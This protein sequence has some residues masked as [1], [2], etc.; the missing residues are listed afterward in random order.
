[1]DK[2]IYKVE[3]IDQ[4]VRVEFQKGA[5][6]SPDV[7]IE[8]MNYE[9]ELFDIKGRYDFWDF[10]GC[11]PSPNFGYDAMSRVV[12]HITLNYN[13]N[14]S[15]KTALLVDGSTQYGLSRMFQTLVDGYPTHIG[16]FQNE[17]DARLWISQKLN[18][19]GESQ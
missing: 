1:M 19:E 14:W 10:R 17:D 12:E 11:R 5:V 9:N 4:I 6:I 8:A 18:T 2:R 15:D 13:G 3:A 7:I 16:I